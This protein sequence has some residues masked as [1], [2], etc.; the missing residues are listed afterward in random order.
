MV[1]L[2]QK[3]G[4]RDMK[5]IKAIREHER[6]TI[7]RI[8]N[9]YVFEW[10]EDEVSKQELRNLHIQ[11]VLLPEDY[12][13]YFASSVDDTLKDIEEASKKMIAMPSDEQE[14]LVIE[15][16]IAYSI[17]LN[18]SELLLELTDTVYVIQ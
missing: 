9:D 8:D 5:I 11:A 6:I 16:D 10:D 3:H 18:Q 2:H 4:K 15:G 13:K 14:E 7:K 12:E 1:I 17:P